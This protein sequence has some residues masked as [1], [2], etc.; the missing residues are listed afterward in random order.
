MERLLPALG[1]SGAGGLPAAGGSTKAAGFASPRPRDMELL[2]VAKPMPIIAATGP[3][4]GAPAG[5]VAELVAVLADALSLTPEVAAGL[6]SASGLFGALPE[7]DSMAVA[8]VLTALEDRF[9][10]IIDDDEVTG[11]LFETVGSLAAFVAA[12]QGRR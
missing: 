8:T 7:L 6:D 4:D 11:A 2:H 5:S 9:G 12:K 10:I 1:Q 3:A